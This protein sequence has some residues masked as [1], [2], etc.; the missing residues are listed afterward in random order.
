MLKT[1]FIKDEGFK[2]WI[3]Y[4]AVGVAVVLGVYFVRGMWVGDEQTSESPWICITEG[5][6]NVLD[7]VP[8]LGDPAPP[9]TCN[10][11]GKKSLVPAFYCGQCG[12]PVTMNYW[13]DL[14]PPTKCPKCGQEIIPSD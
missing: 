12:T 6:G 9:H 11:C 4:A 2:P 7:R 13:R 3:L 5:C 1:V 8:Q 10:K 14:P